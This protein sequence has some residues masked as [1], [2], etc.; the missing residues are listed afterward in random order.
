MGLHHVNFH[1]VLGKPIFEQDHY[2]KMMRDS[3]AAVIKARQL[4]CPVWEV[5]PTHVHM[6]I[7][8]FVDLPR[9]RIMQYLKGDTSRAFFATY[10]EL[11]AD[12]LGGHLWAKG[13]Y[14]VSIVT[15]AQFNATVQYIRQNRQKAGLLPPSPLDVARDTVG[16]GP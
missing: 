12:L 1:T 2:D 5:M 16:D 14:A 4:L 10:P 3:I 11:R 13:Y 9:F 6:I 8:D 15:Y 7:E